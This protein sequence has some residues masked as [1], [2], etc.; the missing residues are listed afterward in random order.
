MGRRP[1]TVTVPAG[2]ATGM[3]PPRC[4]S[5]ATCTPQ[6]TLQQRHGRNIKS[7]PQNQGYENEERAQAGNLQSE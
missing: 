2:S 1:S 3:L 6:T 5:A 7:R 4:N